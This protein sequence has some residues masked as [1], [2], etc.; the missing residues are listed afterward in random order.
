MFRRE[1]LPEDASLWLN[2][3]LQALADRKFPV[4]SHI[5]THYLVLARKPSL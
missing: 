2:R 1:L 5:G 3:R 4:V